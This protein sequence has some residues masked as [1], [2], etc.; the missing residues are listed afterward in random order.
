LVKA[1]ST[2]IFSG[3][4]VT[5]GAASQTALSF[6]RLYFDQSKQRVYPFLTAIM[7]VNKGVVRG[8]TWDD[9]CVF[10]GGL[11]D[12]CEENTYNYNGVAQDRKSARQKTKS[13]YYSVQDCDKQLTTN[14]SSTACDLTLYTV[15]SGTDADGKALQSQAFRFS[16][17][18]VQGLADRFT[19]AI[20]PD[21][22]SSFVAGNSGG[23]GAS[24]NSS[25][26]NSTFGRQLLQGVTKDPAY[27]L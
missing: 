25:T 20:V 1:G 24:T 17:F 18:P 4:N 10:C 26:S 14:S 11:K 6:L 7:D 9:A 12:A 2:S 3:T 16:Q 5:V 22:V 21:G 8:I 27:D 15:W 19:Q 13:C 23:T